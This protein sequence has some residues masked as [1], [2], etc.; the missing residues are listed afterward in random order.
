MQSQKFGVEIETKGLGLA[1]A[2]RVIA[3]TL[4]GAAYGTEETD[5]A[6]GKVWK[7]VPDGSLHGVSAE[8]VTPI[9]T[10]DEIPKLQEVVRALRRAGARVDNECGLHVHV[11]A[12]PHDAAS[13]AR[14]VKLINS[15]ERLLFKAVQVN[16]ARLR[17]YAR[18]VDQR[19][20]HRIVRSAPRSLR[21]LSRAWYGRERRRHGHYDQTR[22]Y[23][24]SIIMLS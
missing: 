20:L 7:A 8:I 13:L 19:F 10:C 4:G 14:L 15:K 1:E 17:R 6:T 23:A 3:S 2:S 11:D 22:Y 24:A 5:P 12:S 16:E 18:G 9:L 21:Q